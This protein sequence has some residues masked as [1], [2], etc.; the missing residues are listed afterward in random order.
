MYNGAFFYSQEICKYFIPNIVTDR[1]WVTIR[2][3]GKCFNHSIVFIHN[4]NKPEFYDYLKEYDDLILVCGVPST[5]E[6]V[7]HL[8]TPIY[9]PLSIDVEYV[10]RFKC[11]KQ[12]NLAYVGR[13]S[14]RNGYTFPKGTSFIE[15]VDRPT[16]LKEMARFK[17]VYAVGRTALEAK[18]L[19]CEVLPFDTRY[20]DVNL[21][22]VI[23]SKD[24]VSLLQKEI[25]KIDKKGK[26]K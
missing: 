3:E 24:A 9:L 12:Y 13:R 5:C 17:Q 10:K 14:K 1:N 18:V 20:P 11:D 4:N 23:D 22:Q 26:R 21:W 19:D 15:G 8:G 25:D 6:K 2:V 7:A 16:L